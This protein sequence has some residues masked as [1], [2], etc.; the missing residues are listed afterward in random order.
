M[1]KWYLATAFVGLIPMAIRAFFYLPLNDKGSFQLITVFDVILCG[2]VL[3]ICIFNERDRYFA[4][5]SRIS[6]VSTVFSVGL[7]VAFA[8]AYT[9]GLVNEA[10]PSFFNNETLLHASVIFTLGSFLVGFVFIIFCSPFSGK[11][12]NDN[13]EG[14]EHG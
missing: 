14:V 6:S 2:M 7:I 11:G 8:I 12:E 10:Q 4:N 3:N 9:F 1:I 13:I 5:N